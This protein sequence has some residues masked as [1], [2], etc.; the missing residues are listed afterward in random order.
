[1]RVHAWPAYGAAQRAVRAPARALSVDVVGL[2]AQRRERRDRVV[3]RLAENRR[4]SIGR[5]HHGVSVV[6]V[7]AVRS[8]LEHRQ[9]VLGATALARRDGAR[10]RGAGDAE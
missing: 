10:L 3:R 5:R 1:T 4:P 7:P 2:A 6:Y 9:L 8:G